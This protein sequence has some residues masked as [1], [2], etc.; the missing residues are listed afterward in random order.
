MRKQPKRAMLLMMVHHA[1]VFDIKKKKIKPPQ[2][3]KF[4]LSGKSPVAAMSTWTRVVKKIDLIQVVSCS[5]FEDNREQPK[6]CL[7]DVLTVN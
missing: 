1:G 3:N 4:F 5:V 7:V 2:T 6:L